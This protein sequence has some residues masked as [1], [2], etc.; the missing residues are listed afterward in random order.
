MSRSL[1]SRR[2]SAL[3]R[4]FTAGLG[5]GWQLL[6]ARLEAEARRRQRRKIDR[7]YPDAGPLRWELYP[8]HLEHFRKGNQFRERMFIAGNRVGKTDAAAYE[9]TC[10]LTGIYPHW[11]EG[12]RFE[13]AVSVL[14]C[15]ETNTTVRDIVQVALLGKIARGSNDPGDAVIGLGTGMIPGD[16]IRST[17]TRRGIPNAIELA[18]VRHIS[19][20]TSILTLKSYE[21]GRE[22]F[23]GTAQDVVWLDEEPDEEIY[24]EALMRTMTTNGILL[25][26]FTPLKGLTPVVLKFLPGGTLP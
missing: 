4:S 7:Y 19:G 11:W 16:L 14:A 25:L 12:R 15:G 8:K 2:D 24:T 18:F 3:D 20:G 26:T 22:S 23:A 21:S 5:S 10:H 6:E 17:R 13:H 1:K 9:V